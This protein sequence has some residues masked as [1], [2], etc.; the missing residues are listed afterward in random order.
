MVPGCTHAL[1]LELDDHT[2]DLGEADNVYVSIV[3]GPT[4]LVL[5]GSNV[6]TDVYRLTVYPTQEQ[7]LRFRGGSEAKIQV[8]WTYGGGRSGTSRMA[9]EA[10]T[11]KVDEQLLGRVLV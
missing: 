8:N 7:S 1:D 3:Q 5:S 4:S 9:T 11:I 10:A 2:I 6:V